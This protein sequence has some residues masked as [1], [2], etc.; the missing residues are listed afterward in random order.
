MSNFLQSLASGG[1]KDSDA[2]E[3]IMIF[4]HCLEVSNLL[5]TIL[6][7]IHNCCLFVCLLVCCVSVLINPTRSKCDNRNKPLQGPS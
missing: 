7:V 6:R 4:V 3:I 2:K 5:Y 1:H